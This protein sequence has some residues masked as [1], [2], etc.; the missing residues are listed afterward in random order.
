MDSCCL[1]EGFFFSHYKKKKHL[2]MFLDWNRLI[3]ATT[4]NHYYYIFHVS[5]LLMAEGEKEENSVC[6]FHLRHVI[7]SLQNREYWMVRRNRRKTGMG[8]EVFWVWKGEETAGWHMVLVA[9]KLQYLFTGGMHTWFGHHWE[10]GQNE[11]LSFSRTDA[12]DQFWNQHHIDFIMRVEENGL[13]SQRYLLNL[14]YISGLK[15]YTGML[16]PWCY[17]FSSLLFVFCFLS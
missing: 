16:S 6:L 12:E 15:D 1:L 3:S 10:T 14:V 2:Q 5:L 8:G 4:S 9:W 7:G 13:K 17:L 11:S